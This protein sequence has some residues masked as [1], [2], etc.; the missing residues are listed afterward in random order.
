[1]SD[2]MKLYTSIF[3][4]IFRLVYLPIVG[5]LLFYPLVH[6]YISGFWEY[7][8]LRFG[9]GLVYSLILLCILLIFYYGGVI[10]HAALKQKG[11]VLDES[12]LNPFHW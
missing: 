5:V 9:Y 8:L 7:D 1:M 12:D 11:S 2:F 3:K 4:W 10:L 6:A